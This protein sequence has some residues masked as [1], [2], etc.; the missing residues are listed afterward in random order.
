[1]KNLIKSILFL[2][3]ILFIFTSCENMLSD[4]EVPASAPK[5]VVTGFLSPGDDTISILVRK[6]LPLYVSTP[7]EDNPFPYV[8][9][10]T[11]TISDGA[12]SINLLFNASN[13]TYDASSTLMPVTAGKTY[14]ILIT[15]PDGF[16]VTSSCTVPTGT[17]PNVEITGIDTNNQ[18]GSV[19]RNVSLRFLDLPGD[20]N[21]YRIAA[22]I[23]QKDEF[24]NDSY[25]YETGFDRGE[26]FVSDKNK[27]G[28]YFSFRTSDIYETNASNDSLYVSILLT[29]EN[30]YNYHRS[31]N[32]FEGENPFA[33]PTP[34]FSNIDGGVGVFAAFRGKIMKFYIGN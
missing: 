24:G 18:Y 32:S 27:E 3:G 14:T 29:D 6:S 12:D 30:Y 1:M 28:E 21:F 9:N 22:G 31:T 19:L 7:N 5:L 26:P 33:E 20:G 17:A 16:R 11:V 4:V 10:A 15:T 13:G 8:T 25:F 2:S 23:R 34:I